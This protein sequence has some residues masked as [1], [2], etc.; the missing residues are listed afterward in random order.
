MDKITTPELEQAVVRL[1]NPRL[2][3]IVPN[4]SWGLGLRHECDLLVLDD[5]N[6]FTE[7]ELKV[8]KAD[9]KKDFHKPH[10]HCC[11]FISR[12]VYA[13]P[14][15]LLD[16]ARELVPKQCGIIVA[17]KQQQYRYGVDEPIEFWEATWVRIPKHVPYR[18][19][20]EKKINKFLRLGT[21][22]IW[23]NTRV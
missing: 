15:Y 13:V 17:R 16:D 3:A 6:R 20:D 5:K 2:N 8:S 7:V 4:V 9:L 21:I 11:D 14:D 12:L 22:R 1:L 18:R 23:N 19:P 10:G